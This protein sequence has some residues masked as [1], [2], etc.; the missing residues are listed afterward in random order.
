[1]AVDVAEFQKRLDDISEYEGVPFGRVNLIFEAEAS[2]G[3]A[4]AKFIGYLHLSDA[5]KSLFLETV[6][7][8]NTELRPKVKSPL[9]E[10]YPLFMVRL[11][12]SFQTLCGSERISLNGY[13]HHGYTL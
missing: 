5:F 9:S 11:A 8:V 2:Y 10:F 3:N 13:P 12:H 1:M 6:E 4:A 7:L